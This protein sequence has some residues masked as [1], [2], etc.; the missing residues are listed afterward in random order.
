MDIG[1]SN[2]NRNCKPIIKNVSGEEIAQSPVA[3]DDTVNFLHQQRLK[4]AKNLIIGD[5]NI[6]SIRNKFLDFKELVLSDTGICLIWETKLDDSFLDQQFHVNGY[7]MFRKIRNKFRG[8]LIL[9]VKENIPCK[10]LNTFRF[11]EE[12]E[13]ISIDFSISNK[14]WLL[15]GIYNPPPQNEALF[16][17][18]IKLALN[19]YST[20]YEN[21]ILLGDFN[22]TTE[23]SKL[24]DLMHAFFLEKLIK[25]P[26][27]FKSTVPTTIDLIVTNQKS[28]FMKSSSYESGLSDFHK[29]ITTIPRKSISKRNPGNILYR[30]Y[31]IFDQKKFED[32]LRSQLASIKTVD[33]SQFHEIFSETLDAIAPVK[34]E[35]TLF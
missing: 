28:L 8:G 19:T 5:L 25:E 10:V 2:L 29:L 24:Q 9:F 34:K 13:I 27:C 23:N 21:L 31:K 33:Y 16:V 17:E 7:K 3:N 18:Q 22:M 35:N 4:Y 12:C 6:N 1:H 20:T 14:K 15:L 11:S 26:T 32:Q 30:D